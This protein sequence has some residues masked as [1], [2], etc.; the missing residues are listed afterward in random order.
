[1][2]LFSILLSI[3]IVLRGIGTGIILG[4]GILINPMQ[5]KMEIVAYANFVKKMYKGYGVKIYAAMTIIGSFFNV[6]LLIMAFQIEIGLPVRWLMI[7]AVGV[8]I[9]AFTGTSIAYPT[10]K[11]LWKT[12]D[13]TPALLT[14]F[15]NKFQF[16]GW[17]SAIAHMVAFFIL[18]SCFCFTIKINYH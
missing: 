15:L 4:T 6:L 14:S 5:R 7:V 16:W 3:T 12:N 17:V 2:N 8:T 18:V 13:D 10:M 9:I 1:M 11:K